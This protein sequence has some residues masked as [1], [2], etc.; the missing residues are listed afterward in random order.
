MI[1]WRKVLGC[2]K[3]IGDFKLPM[4]PLTLL[5]S[6]PRL[7]LEGTH[8]P[9]MIECKLIAAR[10]TLASRTPTKSD[11]LGKVWYLHAMES[12]T[13]SLNNKRGAFAVK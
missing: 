9:P 7:P 3:E 4:H 10:L 6:L 11:W 1:Y 2:I 13:H 5:F 8:L 12:L